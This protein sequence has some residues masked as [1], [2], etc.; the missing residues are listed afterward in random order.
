MIDR[1]LSL[2]EEFEA[3]AKMHRAEIGHMTSIGE[4]LVIEGR[5]QACEAAAARIRAE[6]EKAL[7]EDPRAPC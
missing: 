5:A 2:A 3:K 6:V 4:D 7:E 1:Y